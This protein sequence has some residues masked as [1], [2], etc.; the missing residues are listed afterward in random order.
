MMV[1]D[2]DVNISEIKMAALQLNVLP[3]DKVQAITDLLF[4][5]ANQ[6]MNHESTF[7]SNKKHRSISSIAFR[8]NQRV[9]RKINIK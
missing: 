2:L 6:I 7:F 4:V 3:S 1:K 9:K 8:R 5:I